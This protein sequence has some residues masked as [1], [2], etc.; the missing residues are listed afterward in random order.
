[1]KVARTAFHLPYFD[2]RMQLEQTGSGV[3]YE[4]VRKGGTHQFRGR[5]S[6]IGPVFLAQPDSIDQWLTERYC[7]YCST[8]SGLLL[9]SE[10]HHKP[11]PLQHAEAMIEINTMSELKLPDTAPLLHYADRIDVVGWLPEKV[12]CA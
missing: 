1:M 4:S 11:W 3:C 2:A 5:Y 6:P 8:P 9:R 10:I 7:F 12:G